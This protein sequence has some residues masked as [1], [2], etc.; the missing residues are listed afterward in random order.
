MS[1]RRHREA[2][3]LA[4]PAALLPLSPPSPS[5]SEPPA[6]PLRGPEAPDPSTGLRSASCL[7]LLRRVA[8]SEVS[9]SRA[10]AP[11]TRRDGIYV[12]DL[13]TDYGREEVETASP[14]AAQERR[15]RPATRRRRRRRPHVAPTSALMRQP[16]PAR[17]A[18]TKTSAAAD[19]TASSR[20]AL[21][22]PTPR[23]PPRGRPA[24]KNPNSNYAPCRPPAGVQR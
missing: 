4:P 19:G 17:R 3:G 12:A 8:G 18:E 6:P 24:E 5:G 2:P 21:P 14:T 16:R 23:L 9:G 1:G 22:S 15:R 7:R 13:V 20:P 10:G 11:L